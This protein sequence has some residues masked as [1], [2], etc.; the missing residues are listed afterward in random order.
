MTQ[1]PV[2]NSG[3]KLF[4]GL[5]VFPLLIAVGMIILLSSVVLMTTERETPESLIAAIKTGKAGKRAQKAYE[6]SNELNRK[7]SSLRKDAL[8]KEIISVL[9]DR[10]YDA[11]TR[12]YMAIALR[13]SGVSLSVVIRTTLER[14]IIMPTAMSKGNTNRPKKSFLP[15]LGTGVCVIKLKRKSA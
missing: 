15:E 5:F 14:R 3:R 1:T 2:P 10:E 11:A 9:K 12:R 4:F 6:L 7:N 13:D 8:L